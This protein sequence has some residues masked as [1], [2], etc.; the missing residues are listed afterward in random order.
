MNYEPKA[1]VAVLSRTPSTLRSMLSGLPDA[2]LMNNEGPDTWSPY[3]V[4]GHLVHGDRSDWTQRAALI[5]EQGENRTFTPFNRTAMYEESKG[6]TIDDL[7]Q[8]FAELRDANLG[9]FASWELDDDKLALTGIHP[10]FG[11]VTL[12]QLLSTWVA[13][14]LSHIAQISRV[15]AKQ[16]RDEIGP[17]REFLPIMER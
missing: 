1:A 17:W 14:D 6:K 4:V 3:D 7:L 9:L 12:R 5:L 2:W 11:T 8:E 16:Y 10:K 15:M 13:H